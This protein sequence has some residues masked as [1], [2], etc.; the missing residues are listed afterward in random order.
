MNSTSMA[1][2]HYSGK[3][4]EKKVRQFMN[5]LNGIDH[6]A[7]N[8]PKK[9]KLEQPRPVSPTKPILITAN[10]QLE[11]ENSA[12]DSPPV[13]VSTSAVIFGH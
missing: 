8:A 9:A 7:V 12:E 6:N 3:T 4:H 10:L 11:G 2:L 1:K 5:N 13:A